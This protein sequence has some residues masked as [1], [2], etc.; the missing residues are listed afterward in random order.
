[1]NR[2]RTILALMF[3][4]YLL[5][6]APAEAACNP[7][8]FCSCTVTATGVSFGTYDPLSPSSDDA[9]GSVR[10]R[11][12]L[13]LALNGS[14]TVDLSTGSSGSY[15]GRTMRNGATVLPYNLYT[16][17]ARTQI[18]GNGTGSSARVTRTFAGLLVVDRTIPVYGR[19]LPRQNVRS[20]P[21]SD[22]IVVTVTY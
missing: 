21:Y 1:M 22:T 2:L 4:A 10:V 8:S 9:S 13:L 7:L 12:T 15:A 17:A 5:A 20:G 11:C 3:G 19:I 14:F 16:N 6:P 18:W